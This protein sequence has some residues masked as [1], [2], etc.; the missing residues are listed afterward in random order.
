MN[1]YAV[2]FC[3]SVGK[4]ISEAECQILYGLFIVLTAGYSTA[5]NTI[6]MSALNQPKFSIYM[7]ETR[8]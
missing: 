1:Y 5:I 3:Q 4:I 2:S 7:S 8:A 6:K